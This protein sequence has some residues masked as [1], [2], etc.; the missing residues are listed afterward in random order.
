MPSTQSHSCPVRSAD[1]DSS[2]VRTRCV[3]RWFRTI[4]SSQFMWANHPSITKL[5]LVLIA[6]IL[7]IGSDKLRAGG[8]DQAIPY[9]KTDWGSFLEPKIGTKVIPRGKVEAL[10]DYPSG[11]FFWHM[12]K[13]TDVDPSQEFTVT[14]TK[15]LENLFLGDD[16]FVQIKPFVD[17]EPSTSSATNSDP[18]AIGCWV[19]QGREGANYAES[20]LP[21]GYRPQLT[22]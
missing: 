3:P 12:N 4:P 7:L 22:K 1:T 20:L 16:Y 8:I 5:V 19:Y 13:I 15:K 21:P 17:A 6:T 2:T 18:C 10:K 9:P 14:A 11:L